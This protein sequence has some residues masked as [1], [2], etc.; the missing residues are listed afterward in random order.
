MEFNDKTSQWM[1]FG[2]LMLTRSGKRSLPDALRNVPLTGRT[3]TLANRMVAR[4]ESLP[5]PLPETAPAGV[6]DLVNGATENWL[7]FEPPSSRVHPDFGSLHVSM[8][9]AVSEIQLQET[10]LR[11]PVCSNESTFA[12]DT[13]QTEHLHIRGHLELYCAYCAS[14]SLWELVGETTCEE[15][16]S[17]EVIL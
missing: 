8:P 15:Q 17:A 3:R 7:P 12:L 14:D 5:D 11:C 4:R 1:L 13:W 10:R 6:S 2:A 16:Q 9:G